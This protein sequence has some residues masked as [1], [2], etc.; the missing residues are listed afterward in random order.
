MAFIQ[1]RPRARKAV[2]WTQLIKEGRLNEVPDTNELLKS[3]FL[4]DSI[5]PADFL[6][7]YIEI[8]GSASAIS[9]AGA[10]QPTPSALAFGKGLNA[11]QGYP[12]WF[13][14]AYPD[15]ALWLATRDHDTMLRVSAEALYGAESAKELIRI[16]GVKKVGELMDDKFQEFNPLQLH[17]LVMIFSRD[18]G[19]R[20]ECSPVPKVQHL[21]WWRLQSNAKRP[22]NSA[23]NAR[24]EVSPLWD[25]D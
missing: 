5:N 19:N 3:F 8:S 14:A 23:T 20:L 10:G 1:F 11:P 18:T 7:N 6:A 21:P 4:P 24:T 17:R 16:H 9:P 13:L 2:T 15:V 25:A 12:H 22:P